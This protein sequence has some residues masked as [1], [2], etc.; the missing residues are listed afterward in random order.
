MSI[1]NQ[2]I[3][4]L[5]EKG[6]DAY[7]CGGAVRDIF[8]QQEPN[9]FDIVT[10]ALP[11]QIKEV[12]HDRKVKTVGAN[13]LVTLVDDIEIS[14]Y[15]TDINIIDGRNNCITNACKTLTE[16]LYRRDF[17]FNAMAL[18]PYSGDLVDHFNGK[19]DLSNKL[20]KFVGDPDKRIHEDFLRMI[21][22]ARFACL[23]DGRIDGKSFNLI[24]KNKELIRCVSPERIRIE[25]IKVM[26]YNKPSIFFNILHEMELLE[27]ILPE[28]EI[29]YEHDGGQYHGE[30][31]D[32][33]SM[34]TGDDLSPK[35]P[36]L[37]LVGYLHDVGKPE[38]FK[39]NN[40][41]SFVEHEKIGCDMI[42]EI[43]TRLKFSSDEINRA[44]YIV[45]Y[46]MRSLSDM[47]PKG[48]RR[49]LKKLSEHNISWKDYLKLKI[50]DKKA[51]LSKEDYTKEKIKSTCIGIY[52]AS[53]ESKSGE[54]KITDLEVNGNDIMNALNIKPGKQVGEILNHLLELVIEDPEINKKDELIKIII[55]EFN[56]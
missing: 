19:N 54:F 11:T 10:N 33:H 35:D 22:A 34:I 38:A 1:E 27:I 26:R 50:A 16:D 29:L 48:Y 28:M 53:H 32:V 7:L 40:N 45:L 55:H 5:C 36:I 12:F 43:F 47:S 4:K 44:K 42:E 31:L 18:C 46:H 2:I 6:F 25:L 15:R 51:N 3:R 20:V 52:K 56:S 30:T 39:I 21:R 23:I 13:F 9:D 8:L 24:K 14:T 17:T 49:L 37:R 41:G